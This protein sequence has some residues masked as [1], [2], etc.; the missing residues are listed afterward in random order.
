V[1]PA[2]LPSISISLRAG[3]LV[4]VTLACVG[5]GAGAAASAALAGLALGAA[6]DLLAGGAAVSGWGVAAR[7]V[8]VPDV[9][10]EA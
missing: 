3:K 10:P 2:Y 8:A 6:V 9:A 5:N 4:I 1:L 7:G